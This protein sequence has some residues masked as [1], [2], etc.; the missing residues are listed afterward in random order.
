V[1]GT[2][3]LGTERSP[4]VLAQLRRGE[5]G[6]EPARQTREVVSPLNRVQPGIDSDKDEL[7][8]WLE[9]VG[10]GRGT[11]IPHPS[12]RCRS[13]LTLSVLPCLGLWRWSSALTDYPGATRKASN[14]PLI[15]GELAVVNLR[16]TELNFLP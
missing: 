8:A 14:P 1:L 15:H 11:G 9:I 12:N 4:H 16:R 7:E 2:E 13:L 6:P 10:Q 5:R 3:G